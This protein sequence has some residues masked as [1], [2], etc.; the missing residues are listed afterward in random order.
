MTNSSILITSSN[1]CG[2]QKRMC[3]QQADTCSGM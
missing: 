1:F 3:G 2:I